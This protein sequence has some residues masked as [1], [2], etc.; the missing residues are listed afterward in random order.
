MR[1]G[2]KVSHQNRV[3]PP[4]P[5]E[6]GQQPI[7]Q[8]SPPLSLWQHFPFGYAP[9]IRHRLPSQAV[10]GS[11]LTAPQ[12]YLPHPQ[13]TF[14][15]SENARS[16]SI[17]SL[18][19][20]PEGLSYSFH[21]MS[22]SGELDVHGES[23]TALADLITLLGLQCLDS[24]KIN[25]AEVREL[26]GCKLPAAVEY[27]PKTCQLCS[28]PATLSESLPPCKD[29]VE[30]CEDLAE[31]GMCEHPYRNTSLEITYAVH[32]SIVFVNIYIAV[33]M[34]SV[35]YADLSTPSI[36]FVVSHWASTKVFGFVL[37]FGSLARTK[38]SSLTSS[39]VDEADPFWNP[40]EAMV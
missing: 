37:A 29:V 36:W 12:W 3:F 39:K 30:T 15:F 20:D 34:L 27:C 28:L 9:L 33:I 10:L 35:Y 32:S 2:V 25:C 22:I 24:V 16:I 17:T 1:S 7:V 18:L 19:N 14:P 21:P 4:H 26:D 23:P 11:Y 31:N 5:I 6:I 38:L 40:G 13:A 8:Y